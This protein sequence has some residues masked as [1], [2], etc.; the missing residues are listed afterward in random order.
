MKT[1]KF[2]VVLLLAA[3]FAGVGSMSAQEK[4]RDYSEARLKL[5]A[6][7]MAL[8]MAERYGLDE[9]QVEALTEANLEW[10]QKRGDAP[11]MRR[12][13]GHRHHRADRHHPRRAYRRGGCCGD[14][15]PA[16]Y[17]CEAYCADGHHMADCPYYDA[18]KGTAP[19]KEELEK[20]AAER[21]QAF[22]ERR[23]ARAAYEESLQ[24]I[25]TEEQYKEYQNRR[26]GARL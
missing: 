13:V 21:K 7:M 23:A 18:D 4:R 2:A 26:P 9:K 16:D 24:K 17:C 19:T 3:L 1:V 25:M 15:R 20:R 22:E 11:E 10:L 8:N 12:P 14:P 5:R 6:E